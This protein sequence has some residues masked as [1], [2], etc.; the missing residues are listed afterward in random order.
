MAN[1]YFQ[2]VNVAPGGFGLKFF[3]PKDGGE[4]LQIAEVT[5]WLEFQKIP[6]DLK[7]VNQFLASGREI[8][9]QLGKGSCPPIRETYKL[10]VSPDG[11]QAVARF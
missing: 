1:G 11:M 10:T 2:L 5:E 7:V 6:Y 8:A 3:P 9:C 4:A